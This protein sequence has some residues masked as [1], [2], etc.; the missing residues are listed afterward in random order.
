MFDGIVMAAVAAEFRQN[1]IG[2]R[3]D[4]IYQPSKLELTMTMRQPGRNI[5]VVASSRPEAARIHITQI[6]RENPLVPP[7]FCMLLRKYLIG[8]RVM[9]V[10]QSGLDRVLEITFLRSREETPKA[11]VVEAMGRHSN[12]A[13]VD[14]ASGMVL[15]SIKHIGSDLSR[16][17]QMGPGIQYTQPPAQDKLDILV[18]SKEDLDDALCRSQ[19]N[20]PS[21]P[22]DRLLVSLFAGFGRESAG[23]V[24][25]EVGL[26]PDITCSALDR[27]SAARLRDAL[28]RLA[29]SI[30]DE[31]HLPCVSRLLDCAYSL[32]EDEDALSGQKAELLNVV[33]SNIARCRRKAKAQDEE[34]SQ[35]NKDLECRKLGELI[36]AN[37]PQIGAG[38]GSAKLADYFDPQGREIEVPLDPRLSAP[39][40]AQRYFRRY[41]RAKRVLE[42]ADRQM[43][44]TQAELKY[45]EQV[46]MTI[47]QADKQGELGAI[48]AELMEQG[49]LQEDAESAAKRKRPKA[50]GEVS[51]LSFAVHGYTVIA[52]R[53]NKENDLITMKM[54]RPDDI[55]MHARGIPGAHVVLRTDQVEDEIP[56]ETLLVTAGI[57]AYFSRGRT[58]SKVAVDYTRRK[59]VKKP[60]GARPGMV[61]YD[62]Q[63]TIMASPE[64]PPSDIMR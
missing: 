63:K 9:H 59:N 17:R 51:L 58:D 18:A 32:K 50:K 43:K 1:L 5:T 48:R 39:E 35:A 29:D 62:H 14:K 7:A 10:A 55:W 53:N 28:L 42:S 54:A 44:V 34:I 36:L 12:I 31:T 19:A 60:K 38:M 56:E 4:K 15:D 33:D 25:R 40:N 11:L 16:V 64:L 6:G 30:R 49:Y 8:S 47:R 24:L 21:V 57:A 22:L 3:V 52:G 46:S 41:A 20:T 26:V 13:L 45:L 2:A 23:R 61:T 37:A 27:D